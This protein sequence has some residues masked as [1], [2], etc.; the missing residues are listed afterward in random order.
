MPAVR[1]HLPGG[2]AQFQ[3]ELEAVVAALRHAAVIADLLDRPVGKMPTG[4]HRGGGRFQVAAG[5]RIDPAV[6]PRH[7]VGALR[8]HG[9]TTAPRPVVLVV[10]AVGVEDGVDTLAELGD[11]VGIVAGGLTHQRR[12]HLGT[13]GVRG[14]RRQPVQ[15]LGDRLQM[16]LTEHP[17]SHRGRSSAA[18]RSAPRS[19]RAGS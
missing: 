17:E 3:P 11:E 12:L 15:G 1:S 7:P 19:G 18:S 6:K 5:F 13:V 14:A 8:S 16:V 4:T 9:Q 2:D 10:V